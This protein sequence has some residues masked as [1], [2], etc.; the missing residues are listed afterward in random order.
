MGGVL[1]PIRT[2]AHPRAMA[3][4]ETQWLDRGDGLRLAYERINGAGPT[5]LWL[6]GFKSDMAGTKAEALARW[7]G[8]AKQGFVRFDYSGHGRSEG[9]FADGTIGRWLAD[10]EA[11]A[12]SVTT[13][14]LVLI[15]SSMGGWLALLLAERLGTRVAGLLLIAPA[16]DFTEALLWAELPEAARQEIMETGQWLR[17]SA[18]D[19]APYPITRALIDDGRRRLLMNRPYAFAGPVRILQGMADPDVPWRHALALAEHL[20]AP[21]LA[22]TLIKDGDH[23]LSRPHDI[24]RLIATAEALASD[25]RAT[26]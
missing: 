25:L 18:Y 13:G 10:A 15:G 19:L 22:L 8:A 21:D 11:I 23:R 9:A 26:G 17:P 14:P 2:F 24:A 16:A 6:S 12:T 1:A 4:D 7:A 3:Q 20:D 5:F